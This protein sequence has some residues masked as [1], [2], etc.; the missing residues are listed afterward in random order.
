MWPDVDEHVEVIERDLSRFGLVRSVF[1]T[2]RLGGSDGQRNRTSVCPAQSWRHTSDEVGRNRWHGVVDHHGSSQP[3]RKPS[4]EQC[5]EMDW[6]LEGAATLC[7]CGESEQVSDR[8]RSKD[9]D[10]ESAYVLM[11][12]GVPPGGWRCE[13]R[14]DDAA[15]CRCCTNLR[16]RHARAWRTSSPRG[17]TN[18]TETL[19]GRVRSI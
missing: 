3:D 1:H 7:G 16:L 17:R 12:W 11:R 19:P 10:P 4:S 13:H 18:L 5:R 8:S 9:S 6:F 15:C 14:F 2:A